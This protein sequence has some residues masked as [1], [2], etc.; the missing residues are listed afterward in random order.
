M[1]WFFLDLIEVGE[2]EVGESEVGEIEDG[3]VREGRE[4]KEEDL[5]SNS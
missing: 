2:S 4:E 5:D 3:V 1:R